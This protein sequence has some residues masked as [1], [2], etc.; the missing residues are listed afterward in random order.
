MG[1]FYNDVVS[2]VNF[3]LNSSVTPQ[4]TADGQLIIGNGLTG[5]PQ[6]G[7]LT[8][9]GATVTITPGHGTINLEATSSGGFVWTPVTSATN[10][11]TLV[12]SNGYISKGAGVVTFILPAAAAVGDTFSI[13]GY[14]N[15]WTLT[16]NALQSIT[17][18][19]HTS[20]VGVL[21]SITATHIRDSITLIC[22]VANSEFQIIESVG[23]LTFI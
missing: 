12:K 18:G 21:G 6:V 5:N 13:A 10:P 15:L 7:T 22:V 9:T 8:S 19:N 4:M 2:C 14:G 1:G 3:N 17:L 20:T 23:N 11:N 16:Q